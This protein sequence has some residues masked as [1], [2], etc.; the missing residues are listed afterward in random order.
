LGAYDD[1]LLASIA[2]NYALGAG[3]GSGY[4]HLKAFDPV[5]EGVGPALLLP[6]SALVHLFGNEYWVPGL[7]T[8]VAIWVLLSGILVHLYRRVPEVNVACFAVVLVA[9]LLILT[10]EPNGEWLMA[11]WYALFG[12]LPAALGV[13]V[14]V[15]LWAHVQREPAHAWVAG[16]VF[17]LAVQ[18]KLVTLLAIVPGIGLAV[19]YLFK[20]CPISRLWA[21]LRCV[22][23]LLVPAAA[24]EA[25]KLVTLGSVDIYRR[26]L[27]EQVSWSRD[28]GSGVRELLNAAEPFV[29]LQ[30][31][32][33][34]NGPVFVEYLH[35]WGCT[36]ALVL[37]VGA[38]VWEL[39][40]SARSAHGS[41]FRLAAQILMTGFLMHSA[42]W[43]FVS[44]TGYTNYL[45]PAFVYL[46]LAAALV[47]ASGPIRRPG[48]L[49]MLT[50]LAVLLLPRLA[51]PP[52]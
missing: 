18:T 14:G 34:A 12:D 39:G 51:P 50:A 32:L 37:L 29:Y 3:Y 2:K 8:I 33:V 21:G 38:L 25:W 28:A 15:L 22:G 1:A 13:G 30:S 20:M 46:V 11:R 44:P 4:P 17:G 52:G 45:F 10:V 36:V 31:R 16:L 49:V 9:S 19:A 27:A 40:L 43:L 26:R 48:S 6:A 23:G 42:W 35:G 5:G 24:V 41:S 47:V 7:T